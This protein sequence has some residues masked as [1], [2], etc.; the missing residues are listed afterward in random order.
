MT[1][2]AILAAGCFWGIE[3]KF[4]SIAGVVDT[5]VGYIGGDTIKPSYEQVCTGTTNHAEA[6]RIYFDEDQVSFDEL[7]DIFFNIH[8]PTTIN[9]QGPDIG[10]QYRSA[11]FYQDDFQRL[12]SENNIK[13]SLDPN[14]RQSLIAEPDVYRKR[15]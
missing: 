5:E 10:T 11:I 7:L 8:N 9:R 15:I 6:V 14:V 13:V 12:S 3:E 2:T 4:S 1:K